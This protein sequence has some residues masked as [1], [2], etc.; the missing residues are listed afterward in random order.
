MWAAVK[1]CNEPERSGISL[2][3][4]AVGRAPILGTFLPLAVQRPVGIQERTKFMF[5]APW[6]NYLD[7][8]TKFWCCLIH[9]RAHYV[10]W[11]K[12]FLSRRWVQPLDSQCCMAVP[13]GKTV[14]CSG[15]GGGNTHRA[16][17]V[18]WANVTSTTQK[19]C[20]P[21]DANGGQCR[22]ATQ[23]GGRGDR[24]TVSSKRSTVFLVFSFFFWT[25]N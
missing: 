15:I 20:H 11:D 17:A 10:P 1:K 25:I 3:C 16:T 12:L 23:Q 21:R 7:E 24:V 9:L 13:G 5:T 4:W 14:P 2:V 19:A 18:L 22:V 6:L 8:W